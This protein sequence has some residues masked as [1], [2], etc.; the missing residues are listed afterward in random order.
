MLRQEPKATSDHIKRTFK[1]IDETLSP[2][3]EEARAEGFTPKGEGMASLD[4]D[5]ET[6]TKA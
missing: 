2:W 4:E 6:P 5:A 3:S 1:R